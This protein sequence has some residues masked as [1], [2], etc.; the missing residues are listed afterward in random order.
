MEQPQ[1]WDCYV[2]VC[3]KDVRLDESRNWTQRALVS[4]SGIF[5]KA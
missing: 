2:P 5:D 4:L 1:V 3:E